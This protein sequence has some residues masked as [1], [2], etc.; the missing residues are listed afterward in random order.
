MYLIDE[1]QIFVIWKWSNTLCTT[2]KSQIKV[3]GSMHIAIHTKK[4]KNDL[5]SSFFGSI[6]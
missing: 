3:V 6:Q 4:L 2:D 5:S 1:E